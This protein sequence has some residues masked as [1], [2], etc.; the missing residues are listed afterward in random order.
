MNDG[1]GPDYNDDADPS[2]FDDPTQDSICANNGP[3]NNPTSIHVTPE[4]TDGDKL[5]ANAEVLTCW[6]MPLTHTFR[7]IV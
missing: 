4:R 2:T 1:P 6:Y 3:N 7:L 5:I